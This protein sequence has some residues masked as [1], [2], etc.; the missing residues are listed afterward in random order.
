MAGLSVDSTFVTG[1]SVD[2][3]LVPGASEVCVNITNRV[4]LVT[5]TLVGRLAVTD[6]CSRTG[7]RGWMK[8]PGR[9]WSY[10]DPISFLSLLGSSRYGLEVLVVNNFLE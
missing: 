8:R 7:L 6:S 10:I 2:N 5:G 1:T 9:N 4:V 3:R